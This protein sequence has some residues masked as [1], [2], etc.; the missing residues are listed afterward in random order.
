[1]LADN[2][3]ARAFSLVRNHPFA[4]RNKRTSYGAMTMF[5]G[6]IGH[7][8]GAPLEDHASVFQRPASGELDREG[9]RAWVS[10]WITVKWL[11]GI[12]GDRLT[13]FAE[14]VRT[15]GTRSRLPAAQFP[16]A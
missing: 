15:P 6:R 14:S 4:D 13:P 1:M 16:A 10:D 12:R 2:A 3:A 7:T 11:I 9:F 8:I 5:L